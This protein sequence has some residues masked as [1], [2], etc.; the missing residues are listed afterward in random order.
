MDMLQ[1][2]RVFILLAHIEEE[3]DFVVIKGNKLPHRPKKKPKLM[4]KN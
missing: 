2:L 4:G 3:D 1:W